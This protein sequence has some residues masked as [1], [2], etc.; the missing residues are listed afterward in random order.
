MLETPRQFHEGFYVSA[1]SLIDECF[2]FHRRTL[3]IRCQEMGIA[4]KAAKNYLTRTP[5]AFA[6][7]ASAAERVINLVGQSEVLGL[8]RAAKPDFIASQVL[9]RSLW[10]V[11]V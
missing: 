2:Q 10:S 3:T 7:P 4:F 9:L 11:A 6:R 8:H 1:A 5:P